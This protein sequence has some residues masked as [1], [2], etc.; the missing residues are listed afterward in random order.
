[1]KKE[2]AFEKLQDFLRA[3]LK[4]FKSNVII[5]ND[6]GFELFD[7]YR[8]QQNNQRSQIYK[9][10]IYLGEFSNLRI[11]VSWCV[12]DKFGQHNF[13]RQIWNLDQQRRMI[14]DDLHTSRRILASISDPWRKDAIRSKT[15]RRENRLQAVKDHLDKCANV[16][17]YWQLRGFN[18]EIARTRRPASNR[19]NRTGF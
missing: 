16:A 5:K 19:S 9:H 15:Q 3:D 14:E 6:H 10:E 13:A 1:M 2:A 8:I 12:A 4:N 11:A 17:K 18:D 7:T